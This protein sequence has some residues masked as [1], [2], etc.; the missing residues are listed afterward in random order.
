[1]QVMAK[2]DLKKIRVLPNEDIVI[3]LEKIYFY[4]LDKSQDCLID[5]Y[6]LLTLD[7]YSWKKFLEDQSTKFKFDPY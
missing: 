7:E 2:E 1:M 6:I 3:E 5:I 4:E